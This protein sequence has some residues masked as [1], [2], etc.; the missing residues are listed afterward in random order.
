MPSFRHSLRSL[1]KQ[2]LFSAIVIVTFAL[3]IGANS[4]VFS[5]I[6]AVLLRPLAYHQPQR[7]VAVLPYDMRVGT[8]NGYDGSAASYPDFVDWRAQNRVFDQMAVYT[9]ES[10]TLTDGNKAVQLQGQAV[11]ADLFA[12][13]GVQPMLGRTF[14]AKE[15]EPG[16]HVVVLSNEIWK[17]RF[18]ADPNILGKSLTLDREQFVVVGVMPPGFSFPVRKAPVELWTTVAILRE[19][20]DGGEPMTEQRGNSFLNCV[21]RLKPGIS[22]S[23]AQAN[24]DTIS[25]A[26]RPQYP[27]SNT[28]LAVK[29][30][31]LVSALVDEAHSALLMLCAMAGCVLLVACLNVA[32]LLLA[33]S[34]SHQKEISIR[35]ALGAGRWQIV[36]QLVAESTLLAAFGGVAG[37]LLAVWG[38]DLLKQFLPAN[39]PRIEQISLDF[40]VV[41]F[42]AGAS[43][44]VGIL[45]GLL[46]AWRVSHAN[47]AGSLNETSRSSTEGVRG[48][49][50][51]AVLVVLEIVLAL[52]LLVSGGLLAESFLR[53]QKVR[54]GFDPVNV[55]TARI[56]LP[57]ATYGK[58]EQAAAFYKTLLARISELP[59]VR[60]AS[61]AWWLPLSGSEITFN[62]DI[63][64]RPVPKAVQPLAQVNAV[65]L[66]YFKTIAV[67]VLRGRDFTARDD[68][69]APLVVIISEEFARQFFPGED[70]IGKRIKPGGSVSPGEPPVRE[71][72]GVVGD[73]HLISLSA[74]PKPEIYV[75]HEQFAV[76]GMSLLVGAAGDPRL[77]TE[78]LRKTVAD[79]DKDVPLFRPHTLVEYASQSVSQPR[80]N[81]ML[82]GLFALIALLLAAAGIFG[83][84]SYTVTQRTQEIG[85]RLALGAQRG[86]VLRLIIGQG[87]RLLAIGL[88]CG[89]AGVFGL[90]HLLQSL[91]FG[92]GAHDL[93]TMFEVTTILSL[94]AFF[95]CWIPAT[96]AARVNPVIALRNE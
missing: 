90:G 21:A 6:N 40:R 48:R 94:V 29:I 77:L 53:L 14:F 62:F 63:E 38:L 75:P 57:N 86:D 39:I 15:D 67:P 7:I 66:D 5:V 69:N 32:N 30:L 54:P 4:A 31:P 80:F 24:I 18:G 3:G 81:A 1:I 37:L 46:P 61:A 26:L 35:A 83:V 23:Q 8:A 44:A 51:R 59:G 76:Q 70:P 45:S 2:P 73:T 47:L 96:R 27:D 74:A 60:S 89:F 88:V 52:V 43:L 20:R 36:K 91:L 33:R 9:N 56:A 28:Y 49:R 11:S 93:A 22:L 95:A 82:V 68:I 55:M 17:S 72:V 13:L 16:S 12:L 41:A 25:A 58:P 10:L 42:T 92:I 87:M 85:I 71:I 84:I 79:Q 64:E 19:S 50:T 34:L 65:A 78:T